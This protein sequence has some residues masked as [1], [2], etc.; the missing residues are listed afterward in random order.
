M[1]QGGQSKAAQPGIAWASTRVAIVLCC[2]GATESPGRRTRLRTTPKV[3]LPMAGD[4]NTISCSHANVGQ[5][6]RHVNEVFSV[7]AQDFASRGLPKRGTLLALP[8][9]SGY[10]VLHAFTCPTVALTGTDARLGGNRCL[11]LPF[12]ANSQRG[13]GEGAWPA[14]GGSSLRSEITWETGRP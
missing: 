2:L 3:S 5:F 6:S 14:V 12:A 1:G 9:R 7:V 10:C 4:S 13:D 11:E 8:S